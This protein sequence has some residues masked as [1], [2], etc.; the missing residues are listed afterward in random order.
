MVLKKT[1]ILVAILLLGL[2]G[3]AHAQKIAVINSAKAVESSP[4]FAAIQKALQAEFTKRNKELMEAQK[5]IKKLED[6]LKKD[7][8]VMSSAEVKR[9]EQDI[10]SRRRKLQFELQES[11]DDFNMRANEERRKL[12]RQVIEVVREIGKEENIDVI[13][14]EGVVYV[15]KDADI[16]DKVIERLKSKASK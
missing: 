10:R 13:L 8:D 5:K 12:I 14:S 15:S 11:K 16:T 4:Q 1:A 3:N 6:Q 7:K 2:V 9:Q